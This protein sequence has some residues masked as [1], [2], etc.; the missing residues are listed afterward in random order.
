LGKTVCMI[1]LILSLRWDPSQ[2]P[3]PYPRLLTFTA[4]GCPQSSFPFLSPARLP[5]LGATLIV[6]PMSILH[7]WHKEIQ[8]HAPSLRITIYE[9]PKSAHASAEVAHIHYLEVMNRFQHSDVILTTY[10]VL[11]AEVNYSRK[12]KYN[13]RG[14]KQYA[15]PK[16][17]LL[18]NHFHRVVL[19]ESQLVHN[20][21]SV[22]FRM[23]ARLSSTSRWCV[24][25]T[26]IGPQGLHD[27]YGLV[28]FLGVAPFALSKSGNDKSDASASTWRHAMRA[29]TDAG[30]RRLQTLLRRIMWRH[31]KVHV[32]SEVCIPPLHVRRTYLSFSKVEAEYYRRLETDCQSKVYFEGS[33]GRLEDRSALKKLESLRQACAHPQAAAGTFL[34]TR[35]LTLPEIGQRLVKRVENE[36]GTYERD[37]CKAYNKLAL[38]LIR[39]GR[40]EEAEEVLIKSWT[41]EDRGV[42]AELKQEQDDGNDGSG[43]GTQQAGTAASRA[44]AVFESKVNIVEPNTQVNQW[45]RVE[46]VTCYHLAQI[47]AR[48]LRS[49]FGVEVEPLNIGQ[50]KSEETFKSIMA[51]AEAHVQA[52]REKVKG[53]GVGMSEVD[54]AAAAVAIHQAETDAINAQPPQL[55]ASSS[56]QAAADLAS[57]QADTQDSL[58]AKY[59]RQREQYDYCLHDLFDL[60]ERDLSDLAISIALHHEADLL[61][62]WL[63]S[64]CDEVKQ[65]CEL[66]L[67]VGVD[68]FNSWNGPYMEQVTTLLTKLKNEQNQW[69]SILTLYDVSH[70]RLLVER[71]MAQLGLVDSSDNSGVMAVCKEWNLDPAKQR[72]LHE[73]HLQC[74]YELPRHPLFKQKYRHQYHRIH[75][76][77]KGQA[78]TLEKTV[79]TA[80]SKLRT[81]VTKR[82]NALPE[83]WRQRLQ[84][85][86]DLHHIEVSQRKYYQYYSD[87][88]LVCRDS[89]HALLTVKEIKK[90]RARTRVYIKSLLD[91]RSH[92]L[93]NEGI[94][95]AEIEAMSKKS[96][97]EE[98]KGAEAEAVD[99]TEKQQSKNGSP[100][101]GRKKAQ[102]KASEEEDSKRNDEDVAR[103]AQEA[104]L[105]DEQLMPI[106]ASA[107]ASRNDDG[108]SVAAASSS[109]SSAAAAA[110][111]PLSSSSSDGRNV[112]ALHAH[113]ISRLKTDIDK[114]REAATQ[115]YKQAA[116]LRFHFGLESSGAPKSLDNH[117]CSI[118]RQ[119]LTLPAVTLCGHYFDVPCLQ[120]WINKK[121]TQYQTPSCPE[122]RHPLSDDDWHA[123]TREEL[124][125]PIRHEPLINGTEEVILGVETNANAD[126]QNSADQQLASSSAN[127]SSS[128]APLQRSSSTSSSSNLPSLSEVQATSVKGEGNLG[129]KVEYTVKYIK[130]MQN[131]DPHVKVLVFSN[132]PRILGMVASALAFNDIKHLH[133]S[134]S[135]SQ[136]ARQLDSFQTDSS[137]TALLLS[138]RHDN[139]GLTLVSATAVILM[140]PSL[141]PSVEAQAINRVHRIGQT[142]ETHVLKL[143]MAGSVEQTIDQMGNEE[144]RGEVVATGA[145][146]LTRQGKEALSVQKLL[147]VLNLSDDNG[148]RQ[149]HQQTTTHTG[150]G[151]EH[152]AEQ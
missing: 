25:G 150:T 48:R 72:Q 50:E 77:A 131:R 63:E 29:H 130:A 126:E 66:R 61:P 7:Q 140:E 68:T 93:L 79:R 47:Y 84:Q 151:S 116:R 26:P 85:E 16:S 115:K 129:T 118:C 13:L 27:L 122:C 121:L 124:P 39:Q 139:S 59:H 17:P 102:K 95:T 8:L 120:G 20:S 114:L 6:T 96:R 92:L 57:G 54:V 74:M 34:G 86:N 62:K 10:A 55:R 134:G 36:G 113:A 98:T 97:E 44:A 83:M 125:T 141:N 149:N 2:R 152:H 69:D 100:R 132:F 11:G 138:L 136:R 52:L 43:N 105:D 37:L 30:L 70:S 56:S 135:P 147:H 22:C 106:A 45:R 41:I 76:M 31:S 101:K 64:S 49:Q 142:R 75:S 110:A 107:A 127:S 78:V 144:R 80:Y 51:K 112:D 143:L 108:N 60:V 87:Q 21:F 128:A 40:E 4:A 88:W 119:T 65:L 67:K 1:A 137:F 23:A 3:A 133:L 5:P 145:D 32:L 90:L 111:A 12:C 19:D 148:H 58:L 35:V 73:R 14:V 103:A 89:I 81:S 123:F 46:L 104:L 33:K 91:G 38:E 42:V 109:S 82:W 99:E 9:G 28:S 18:D 24:S 53:K 71:Q 15:V 146:A 117:L 94:I